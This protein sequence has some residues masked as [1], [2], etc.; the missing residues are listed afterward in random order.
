MGQ[1][2]GKSTMHSYWEPPEVNCWC[3]PDKFTI[4]GYDNRGVLPL[5]HAAFAYLCYVVYAGLTS[6]RL[7]ARWA[8]LPLFVGSLFPDLV[9]KPLAYWGIL[10][11]GRSLGH[12]IF[13]LVGVSVAIWWGCRYWRQTRPESRWS[14]TLAR[15]APAA[16]SIA[17][18]SHLLGDTAR[19]LLTGN[20]QRARFLLWPIYP[21]RQG[22]GSFVAPWTRLLSIYGNLESHPQL[23][24]ILAAAVLFIGLRLRSYWVHRK[25]ERSRPPDRL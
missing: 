22:V 3:G 8:L 17:Y 25:T 10:Y 9:D 7:P 14:G 21:G 18:A 11:S 13:T 6:H 15:Y 1:G 19:P 16:F 2:N 23:E 20:F 4:R 24:L 5:G 12:S